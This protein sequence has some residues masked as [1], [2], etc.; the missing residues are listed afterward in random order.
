MVENKKN[1]LL[2]PGLY[3]VSTPIGNLSDITFRAL[4][5][6]KQSDY[7]LC[8][9]T[10]HSLK[11]LN[12]Y[13]IKKKLKS[14]HK[15]N[16]TKNCQGI[17]D[18]ICLDKSIGLV[19]DAGT[20]LISDPGEVLVRLAREQKIK[21]I[22]IPGASAVTAAVSVSGFSSKFF[23]F[24]FLSKQNNE[25]LKELEFLSKVNNSIVLY[26]PARDLKKNL[27]EFQVYFNERK[28][29]IAREITKLH[30]SYTTGDVSEILKNL[31]PNDL[32]GEITLVIRDKSKDS[33]DIKSI[34]LTYEIK[35]LLN[36]MSSKDIAEYL[37]EKFKMSKKIIY[38]NILEL[39]TIRL[40]INIFFV[41]LILNGWNENYWMYYEVVLV[42]LLIQGL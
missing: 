40:F 34:D 7:I 15:F 24:G 10:R 29:F 11:L 20:P 38:Q 9:D 18:D 36:K 30:E 12:F 27:K 39:N 16:E 28:I 33:K 17:F 8:E 31:K 42:L 32:K 6:L 25:R 14:N 35:L 4:E 26:L 13:K 23:F 19:S 37:A 21:V 2:D 41:F 5:V 3:V 1:N 22:P